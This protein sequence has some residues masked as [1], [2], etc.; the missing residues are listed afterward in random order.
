VGRGFT[1]PISAF[2]R[3]F[4]SNIML[5]SIFFT[6]IFLIVNHLHSTVA[7]LIVSKDDGQSLNLTYPLGKRA[8]VPADYLCGNRAFWRSRTCRSSVD[9]R[10]WV[11]KCVARYG[12]TRITSYPESMCPEN[13]I[14]FNIWTLAPNPKQ[15]IACIDR[16]GGV[17]QSSLNGQTGVFQVGGGGVQ[18]VLVP[19]LSLLAQVSV[20]AL[21]EGMYYTIISLIF[22]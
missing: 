8:F 6:N 2:S 22:T 9:D 13:T 21:I 10:T 4:P 17:A 14:C 15:T 5:F 18:T 7:S 11:D 12:T 3:Y 19:M 1:F 20:S 16:P